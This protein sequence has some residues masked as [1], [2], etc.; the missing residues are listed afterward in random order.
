MVADVVRLHGPH[1]RLQGVVHGQPGRRPRLVRAVRP[2]ARALVPALRR[3]ALF[4]NHV[5]VN[6]PID[7]GK[8]VHEVEDVFV[9]VV[10]ERDDGMVVSGAKML[11]TGSALTHATFVAQNSAVELEK[12]K[13]EDYALSSSRRWTRRAS[14]LRLPRLLRAA[15]AIARST[16]RSPAAS[17]RTTRSR[18][19]QRA[20][21]LGERAR[22]PR[23]RARDRL[24]RA[25]RVLQPLQAAVR[26]AAGG[27]ARLHVRAASP[28]ASRANG[29]DGFRGVQ[30]A[31]G[32]LIGW[33]N[34]IWALTTALCHDPQPGPGESV[35]P[36]R[37]VRGAR[38]PV[39][40]AGVAA[41]HSDLRDR[42][43]AARRSSSPSSDR[44]PAEPAS[45][46]R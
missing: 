5:L 18:L 24:L 16:T 7:R 34:L 42:S 23:R 35:V 9:H 13:A 14:K 29:T 46:A 3:A 40:H 30:A 26:H 20:H 15:R 4:L 17:T 41:R 25:V 11:A 28:R 37:R 32:E 10:K 22:L 43:S 33:R 1:A 45:C 39:R 6:P 12:G 31:L 21:P 44:G 27:Q 8:P 2:T 38:P 36:K 19:R